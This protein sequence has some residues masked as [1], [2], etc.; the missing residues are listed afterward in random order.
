MDNKKAMLQIDLSDLSPKT[1]QIIKGFIGFFYCHPLFHYFINV[2]TAVE[3][4]NDKE[5]KLIRKIM[6][7]FLIFMFFFSIVMINDTQGRNVVLFLLFLYIMLLAFKSR[8]H[9][10]F[11]KEKNKLY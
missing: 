4:F 10:P 8:G 9:I 3:L 1:K 5:V 11:K 7:F 6:I 2:N